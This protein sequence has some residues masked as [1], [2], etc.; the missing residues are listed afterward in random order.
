MV[1]TKF[2]CFCPVNMQAEEIRTA[3]ERAAN[4]WIE[5]DADAFAA[6]FA[7]D[8]EFIVPGKRLVGQAA[9][10][11]AVAD[12]ATTSSEVS[13]QITQ[14]LIVSNSNGEVDHAM[15]EW[16]WENTEKATGHRYR[17]DDAIAIDFRGGRITRWREYIDSKQLPTIPA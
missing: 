11:Q 17:A 10:R 13:I 2:L 8:G 1:N 16:H 9:I 14:I 4:A 12:F 7:A 15:V 5:A 6:L 3:I